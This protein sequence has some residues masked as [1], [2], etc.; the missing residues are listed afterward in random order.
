MFLLLLVNVSRYMAG[1]LP[2]F[3]TVRNRKHLSSPL[4]VAFILQLLASSPS[5]A[6]RTHKASADI[7]ADMQH[8][9]THTQSS[10]RHTHTRTLTYMLEHEQSPI[11]TDL[12][13]G[14]SILR[15]QEI[16]ISVLYCKA[17]GSS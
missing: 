8:V 12:K 6:D 17:L 1:L 2:F 14:K 5:T 4:K 16:R 15:C 9:H 3:P 7:R 10:I 13:P 11:T